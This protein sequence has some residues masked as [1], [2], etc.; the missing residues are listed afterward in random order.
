VDTTLA[1]AILRS[2]L[3]AHCTRQ[4]PQLEWM[5]EMCERVPTL[6]NGGAK[7]AGEGPDRSLEVTFRLKEG[8]IWHDG[9]PVTA[10]DYVYTW[11]TALDP[12]L[13]GEAYPLNQEGEYWLRIHQAEALDERTLVLRYHSQVTLEAEV[14]GQGQF[15]GM[16]AEYTK[17]KRAFLSGPVVS[18]DYYA[19]GSPL[20]EHLLGGQQVAG[21]AEGAWAYTPVGN[22]AYR[23]K[24]WTRGDRIVLEAIPSFPLGE[25]HIKNLVI[26]FFTQPSTQLNA[27]KAGQI[28]G[29][30]QDGYLHFSMGPELARLQEMG[31]NVYRAPS[32]LWEHIDLNTSR[33]PFDDLRV[34]QALAYATDKEALVDKLYGGWITPQ[35]SFLPSY[36]WA[37]DETAVKNY[38]PS[39]M[40]ARSLLTEAGWDCSQSPCTRLAPDGISQSLRFTLLATDR[41]D[42]QELAKQLQAQWAEAGFAVE[43][44]FLPGRSLY[45]PAEA[46][47][48]LQGRTFEA[49][50]FSWITDN[51]PVNVSQ[52][53]SCESIPAPE[54]GFGGYNFSGWCRPDL[55]EA[56]RA[57]RIDPEVLV[58]RERTSALLVEIQKAW[59]S[60]VPVIP[61]YN[62]AAVSAMSSQVKGY[63][64]APF[65]FTYELWNAWQWVMN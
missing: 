9:A 37:Y 56:I 47:G 52:W 34:R 32:L 2:A 3:F 26:R 63:N 57:L 40:K 53:Y 64:P 29:V 58:D 22:G 50:L 46:G 43:L 38:E 59:T 14:S 36:H 4:T 7:W 17:L 31:V 10:Q 33:F 27:L 6:E 42:R 45:D 51:P 8:W 1:G 16:Q 39:L 60:D 5:P 44:Q 35:Q 21:Q 15:P 41:S 55:E 20:P 24:S 30:T 62:T 54:N 12:A 28:R 18:P 11:Q 65:G 13:Y 19:L 25:A 23:L 49:A 48:P 61:L